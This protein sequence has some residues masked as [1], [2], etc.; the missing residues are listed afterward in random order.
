MD[1]FNDFCFISLTFLLR[2]G[3]PQRDL[4]NKYE[5]EEG[6][7]DLLSPEMTS[8]FSF[9]RT[10]Q[11]TRASTLAWQWNFIYIYG[12][13]HSRA[14]GDASCNVTRSTRR[15]RNRRG[16]CA[17]RT[18]A[19]VKN[20]IYLRVGAWNSNSTRNI[21]GCP[22]CANSSELYIIDRSIERRSPRVADT[23]DCHPRR[24]SVRRSAPF[25]REKWRR[26]ENITLRGIS[27]D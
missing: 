27:G 3:K 25:D 16:K 22:V 7:G 8:A 20:W 14:N 1:D 17:R 5:S 6:E 15:V 23:P 11:T 18:T 24:R 12:R 4:R 19:L 9:H 10:C 2:Y 13:R 26:S 21:H